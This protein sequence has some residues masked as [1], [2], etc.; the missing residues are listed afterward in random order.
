[1]NHGRRAFTRGTALAGLGLALPAGLCAQRRAAGYADWIVIDGCGGPGDHTTD[2]GNPLSDRHVADVRDSGITAI[3]L[4]VGTVG[5]MPEAEAFAAIARSI[6]FWQHA[7]DRHP[8]ALTV[9]R[10]FADLGTAKS[11]QRL[12]LVFGLQDGISFQLDPGVLETLH[13]L[14]VRIVQ[15]TYNLR[16]ELGDGC[17][18]PG[19]AGLSRAGHAAIERMNALGMLVDLSHCGERTGREAIAQSRKPV[20]FTHTGCAA[21]HAHPRN[22]TDEQLRAVAEK[23]GVAGIFVMPYLRPQGQ[24]T[25]ADVVRHIEHAIDVMGEE[26]VGV[27]TDGSLSPV[28]LTPDYVAA[29]RETTEKRRQAG[30]AAPGETPDAYLFAREL[31]TPRRLETLGEMLAKRGHKAARIEKILGANFARLFADAWVAGG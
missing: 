10:S 13:G 5:P 20:A 19:N 27:G 12:G 14:G 28:E 31:N 16:N 17:M 26:H 2:Q 22:K 7:V 24:P 8:E 9:V 3:N 6:A 1:M 15:P 21:V 23:G 25:A 30:I 18:E 4:T 29:F 11:T